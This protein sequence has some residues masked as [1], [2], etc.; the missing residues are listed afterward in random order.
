MMTAFN[1]GP[2]KHLELRSE[3]LALI[4]RVGVL[5]REKFEV[6]APEYDRTATFP[7]EDFADLFSAGL[8]AAAIPKEHDGLGLGPYRGE[9]FTL[10]MMTE[11][12]ANADLYFDS[13][14]EGT[15]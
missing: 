7:S 14:R 15:V 3:Q 2:Y 11:V 6:R 4:D 8:N 12:I 1:H 10:W 5:A 13:C 9:V